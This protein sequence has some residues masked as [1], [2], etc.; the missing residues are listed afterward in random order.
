MKVDDQGTLPRTLPTDR[1]LVNNKLVCDRGMQLI[2][3]LTCKLHHTQSMS[4]DYIKRNTSL[5]CLVRLA[6]WVKSVMGAA[7]CNFHGNQRRY[8]LSVNS[9][10]Q[11]S[12]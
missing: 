9:Y 11:L 5:F 3:I 12:M 10:V 8:Q 2:N 4:I 7:M 1:I 6:G